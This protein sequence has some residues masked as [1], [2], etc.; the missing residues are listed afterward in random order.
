M[1]SEKGQT[2]TE[3]VLMIA[4]LTL[5]GLLMM[6][7]FIGTNG[8]GGAVASMGGNGVQRIATEQESD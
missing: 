1:V 2:V 5:L 6:K 8:Q 4:F 3:F 7:T